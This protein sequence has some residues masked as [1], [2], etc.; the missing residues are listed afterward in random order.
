MI[1]ALLNALQQTLAVAVCAL[2]V[3][4]SAQSLADGHDT[5]VIACVVA[6][7]LAWGALMHARRKRP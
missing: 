7:L 3:I 6:F 1:E 2:C 5:G 4:G